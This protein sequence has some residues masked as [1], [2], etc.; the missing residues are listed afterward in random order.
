MARRAARTRC[1]SATPIGLGR[2]FGLVDTRT[3]PLSVTGHVAQ[4]C[5][6]LSANHW[7][8]RTW[9]MWESHARATNALTSSSAT[10]GQSSSSARRTISGVIGGVSGGTWITG[11]PPAAS[12]R[13]GI[14]PRRAS[15]E[16][17]APS[18]RRSLAASS[19]AAATTSSSI[20][21]V[22]RTTRCYRISAS[23]DGLLSPQSLAPT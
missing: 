1:A 10:V 4:P 16:I 21:S 15:S 23:T 18:D 5:D 2:T 14:S 22:V 11:R 8:M 13:A 6:A 19:R 12:T 17:T 7:R 9:W 3:N 20:S